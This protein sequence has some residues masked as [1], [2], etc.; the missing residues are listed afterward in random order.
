[1]LG[2]SNDAKGEFC[3]KSNADELNKKYMQLLG[4]LYVFYKA[5][6]KGNEQVI[7]KDSG[8]PPF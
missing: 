8:L 3:W 5:V 7:Q 1:M 2:Q 4:E 6:Q